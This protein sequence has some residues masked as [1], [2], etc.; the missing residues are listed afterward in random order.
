M[1]SGT[2]V[3]FL[4]GLSLFAGMSDAALTCIAEHA[5]RVDLG[6][7]EV[8]LREGDPAKEMLVVMA[9]RLEVIKRN[10]AAEA[11]IA[12]LGPGEVAGEMALIDIQPRSAEVRSVESAS[13]IVMGNAD[14]A[15]VYREDQKSY[16]LLV[17]N[18]AREISLRLRRLDQLLADLMFDIHDITRG[19]KRS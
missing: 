8:L 11:C 12:T 14:I 18:I 6:P 13:V 10:G 19:K 9:G 5:R 3:D 7:G 17:L 4:R 15:A 16:T 2:D 1:L